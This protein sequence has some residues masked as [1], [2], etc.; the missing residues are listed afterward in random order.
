MVSPTQPGDERTLHSCYAS[1][2][3]S[4]NFSIKVF[5]IPMGQTGQLNGHHSHHVYATVSSPH[6]VHCAANNDRRVRSTVFILVHAEPIAISPHVVTLRYCLPVLFSKI[7]SSSWDAR[8]QKRQVSN[9]RRIKVI[10]DKRP[11]LPVSAWIKLCIHLAQLHYGT[12][13]KPA[14]SS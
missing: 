6:Q 4:K 10:K 9:Q 12:S 7:S 3:C 8:V 2:R 13:L 14:A 1:D 5:V 11:W